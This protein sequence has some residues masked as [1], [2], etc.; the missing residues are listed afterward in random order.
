MYRCAECGTHH[1]NGRSL[2]PSWQAQHRPIFVSPARSQWA[3]PNPNEYLCDKCYCQKFG[4]LNRPSMSAL[5]CLCSRRQNLQVL[6]INRRIHAEASYIF[7]TENHFAFE[8]VGLLEGFLFNLRPETR[9]WLTRI[10]LMAHPGFEPSDSSNLKL[11]KWETLRDAWRMLQQCT[12]L[13]ALELDAAFLSKPRYVRGMRRLQAKRRVSFVRHSVFFHS[14][15]DTPERYIW[16]TL[17][18]RQPVTSIQ[19]S[20]LKK[21]IVENLALSMQG[22]RR[23]R[24]RHL[25]ALFQDDSTS[26]VPG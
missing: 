10:S 2:L 1:S 21:A 20:L 17:A 7:W 26:G 22:T 24:A 25:R 14:A 13:V 16:P 4:R 11:E 15:S 23:M 5:P 8:N 6:L 3:K 9:G 18:F 12:G 19:E